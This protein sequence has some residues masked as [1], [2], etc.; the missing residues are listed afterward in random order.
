M[1]RKGGSEQVPLGTEMGG[2]RQVDGPSLPGQPG[3]E[4]EA[5]LGLEGWPVGQGSPGGLQGITKDHRMV[6]GWCF[7]CPT[8]LTHLPLDVA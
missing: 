6:G 8:P 1:T 5:K 4:D 2:F 7:P 3:A